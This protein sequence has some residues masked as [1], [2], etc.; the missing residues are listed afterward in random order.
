MTVSTESQAL[1]R[2]Y[3]RLTERFKALSTFDQ[4]LQGIHRAFLPV[5]SGHTVDL[6][7][8]YEEL[9]RLG[10]EGRAG[11]EEPPPTSLH[12]LEAK[13]DAADAELRAADISLS[14]SLTRRYFES[15]RPSDPR[16][17][18]YLLR[19]YAS[20]SQTDDDMLDKVDYLATVVA[21]GT[22]DPA[23]SALKPRGEIRKLFDAVLLDSAWPH[24]DDD[25][26]PEIARAF[27]EIAAQIASASGFGNLA[28]EG[29][30]ESLRNFKRQVCRG[31]AH[32]EILTSAAVCNLT[33]RAAFNRLYER[34]ERTL[35]GAARRI[36]EIE[37][38]SS[39]GELADA[40]ALR[41]FDESRREF[42]RQ[43]AEGSVR[44]RQ[45]LEVRLAASEALKMLGQPEPAAGDES[46]AGAE[47]AIGDLE[48][49]FWGPCLRRVLS[50]LGE[51]AT[52]SVE[53]SKRLEEWK[54]EAWEAEAARGLIGGQE[55][56]K[57]DQAVISAAALR[58]K[59]EGETES[60]RQCAGSPVPADLVREARETLSHALELDRVFAGLAGAVESSEETGEQV[61]SWTRTRMRLLHAT[62]ALW[63]A[64]D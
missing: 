7:P 3:I 14:P 43:V 38:R 56:S 36:G 20:H 57:G 32:P 35:R 31:L 1:E 54:L 13:F 11:G 50:T 64:L 61:R 45:L 12:D 25:T 26:A 39:T 16:I 42:D 6:D 60:A 15:V 8:L 47:A 23:A 53:G 48:D 17:P 52:V 10:G 58:V 18:F 49:A 37:Q 34:E 62:S 41:L 27:D 63:L 29:W 30:I 40:A 2:D 22:P 19:F 33:A 55:L 5:R 46:R 59:A 44:W 28:E 4:F 9:K 51:D 24:V 21:A